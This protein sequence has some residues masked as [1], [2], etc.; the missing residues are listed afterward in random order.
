MEP[1]VEIA[2]LADLAVASLLAH[3]ALGLVLTWAGRPSPE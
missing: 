3:A 2:L 1:S